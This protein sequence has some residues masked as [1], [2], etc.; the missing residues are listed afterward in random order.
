[1]DDVL[2]GMPDQ[3]CPLASL[4]CGGCD[5]V[6]LLTCSSDD[7]HLHDSVTASVDSRYV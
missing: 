1:M 5:A 6:C 2:M 3:F 4:D 7:F